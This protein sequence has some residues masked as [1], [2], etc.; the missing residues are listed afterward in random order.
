M[1]QW[2]LVMSLVV[3]GL[4]AATAQSADP[5]PARFA[6]EI[7]AFR[8]SDARN[9]VP[10]RSIVF[11]GSSTIRMWPTAEAFPRLPVVNRGFGGSQISDVNHYLADTVLKHRPDV[12]VFYAGDN[13]I[14]AG[15]SPARVLEDY[16][17]FV[18]QVRAAKPST[19]V[20]FLAI[21]PSVARWKL[22]PLMKEA[23]ERIQAYSAGYSSAGTRLHYVDVA[24]PMLGPGD[25]MPAASLFVQDGL[26]LSAE[27]YALWNRI[28]APV[29]A[30]LVAGSQ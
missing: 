24:T 14:S 1:R 9:A 19:Q 25:S 5:D 18:G 27:G 8:Q 13:D 28:L 21:K 30:G 20:V 4:P 16:R 3:A 26:H 29:L 23:N 11:V 12:V 2:L 15:K 17:T 22:W 6:A 10:A 7:Q